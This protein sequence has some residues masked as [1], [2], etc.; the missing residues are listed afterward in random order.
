MTTTEPANKKTTTVTALFLDGDMYFK[1][2]GDR[3]TIKER[4]K[5]AALAPPAFWVEF[6]TVPLRG[7]D[8][9][10][11]ILAVRPD[12]IVGVGDESEMDLEEDAK[13]RQQAENKIPILTMFGG[14]A[15]GAEGKGSVEL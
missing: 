12:R 10:L 13:R 2:I 4:I 3:L 6:D 14:Q 1:V 15:P 8:T 5:E 11:G 7:G 9:N